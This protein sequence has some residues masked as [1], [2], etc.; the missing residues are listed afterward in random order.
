MSNHVSLSYKQLKLCVR[1]RKKSKNL[2]ISKLLLG[3]TNPIN[4]ELFIEIGV[5]GV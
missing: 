2:Q 4:I 3:V 5:S 1:K